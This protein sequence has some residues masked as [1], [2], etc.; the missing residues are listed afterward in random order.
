[1]QNLFLRTKHFLNGN[2]HGLQKTMKLS[3]E[4]SLSDS[5]LCA[6]GGIYFFSQCTQF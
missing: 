3:F 4:L 2:A 6:A 1:M 5:C